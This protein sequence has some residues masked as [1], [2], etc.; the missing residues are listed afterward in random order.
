MLKQ[1]SL[2]TT[3]QEEHTQELNL[4]AEEEF[5]L[6][7]LLCYCYTTGYNDEP[8]DDEN[9]PTPQIE[10]P[11]YVNR[12]DLNAQMYSIADKYDIPSLKE[13]AVEKFD[14]AMMLANEGKNQHTGASLVD[15][16]IEA[17]P[18][19]YA[20]TP[21]EDHRLRGRAVGVV[22]C[23]RREFWDHPDLKDLLAAVPEFFEE[24]YIR[25]LDPLGR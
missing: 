3:F 24:R 8:Y 1:K 15:E 16:V 17:I 18:T 19:I 11:P 4:P 23:N 20:L 22:Q 10:A 7:R 21:D 14:A 25:S 13:K 2:L 5:L 12:L 6:R 9:D